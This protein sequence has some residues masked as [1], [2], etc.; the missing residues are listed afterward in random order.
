MILPGLYFAVEDVFTLTLSDS[1]F[2]TPIYSRPLSN[3]WY[4]QANPI[5]SPP[6]LMSVPSHLSPKALGESVEQQGFHI[7][8]DFSHSD[9]KESSELPVNI[10]VLFFAHG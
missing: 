5:V 7:L 1:L 8:A 9:L 10:S 6:L 3:K 2:S 4:L